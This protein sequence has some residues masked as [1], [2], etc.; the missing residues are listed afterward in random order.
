MPRTAIGFGRL[1]PVEPL[2]PIERQRIHSSLSLEQDHKAI[3][4]IEQEVAE[5]RPTELSASTELSSSEL[6]AIQ[7][8]ATEFASR[9][10]AR[11][12][13][14]LANAGSRSRTP[15]RRIRRTR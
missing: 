7:A 1:D 4:R 15:Q 2:S 5:I 6:A 9:Y 14:N 13:R 8:Y 12:L 11:E 10:E 3:R